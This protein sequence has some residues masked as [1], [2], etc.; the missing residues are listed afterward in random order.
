VAVAQL[1]IVSPLEHAMSKLYA[2]LTIAVIA[3]LIS[4]PTWIR[5]RR[6]LRKYWDRACM[7]IR[8]RRRFPD[9]TKTDIRKF[10][11]TLVD[12]FGFRQSRRCC[13]SPDDRLMDVY[14]A[15]YPPGSLSD[16]LELEDFG[17]KLKERY[18]VDL[19]TSWRD[20]ITLGELYAQTR[21]RAG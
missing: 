4:L 19:F 9:S 11:S 15:L 14:R 13:F 21:T 5:S 16:N 18:G 2:L 7:G 10:L 1:W 17:L 20:D 6:A 8:W 3:L 12:A